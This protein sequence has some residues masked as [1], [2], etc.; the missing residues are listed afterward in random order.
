MWQ[1]TQDLIADV[2]LTTGDRFEYL[3]TAEQL[4]TIRK[5]MHDGLGS[6]ELTPDTI[7]QDDPEILNIRAIARVRP[8]TRPNYRDLLVQLWANPETGRLYLVDPDDDSTAW[9]I[10]PTDVGAPFEG[11]PVEPRD[12]GR[13]AYGLVEGD[14]TLSE[15]GVPVGRPPAGEVRWELVA[16]WTGERRGV[17]LIAETLNASALTYLASE[18]N[19]YRDETPARPSVA[20]R[21]SDPRRRAVPTIATDNP[22]LDITATGGAAHL[23]DATGHRITYTGLARIAGTRTYSPGQLLAHWTGLAEVFAEDAAA[24]KAGDQRAHY[25]DLARWTAYQAGQQ[26]LAAAGTD[27]SGAAEDL[28]QRHR[29]AQEHIAGGAA[30]G[31]RHTGRYLEVLD[32]TFARMLL[33]LADTARHRWVES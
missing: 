26:V 9:C 29:I 7:R 15:V 10:D 22:D 33:A 24:T 13:E 3:V 4:D 31:S 25:A 19:R 11:Q 5:K 28:R 30:H 18:L 8:F 27:L 17:T 21:P 2:L 14:L 12:F 32:I 6:V 23:S 16:T 1:I 20:E